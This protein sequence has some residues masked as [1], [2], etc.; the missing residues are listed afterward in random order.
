MFGD[1]RKTELNMVTISFRNGKEFQ[2]KDSRLNM[3]NVLELMRG[4]SYF[5]ILSEK[6]DVY[7]ATANIDIILINKE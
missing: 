4:G 2:I 7:I 3:R 1:K 5:T 6:Q